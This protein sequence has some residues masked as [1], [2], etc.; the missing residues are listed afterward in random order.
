MSYGAAESNSSE[1]MGLILFIAGLAS[2]VAAW[3]YGTSAVQVIF[4][5]LGLLGVAGG[6]GVLRGQK[7]A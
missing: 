7:S 3:A 6:I 1:G 2:W 5:I 4:V